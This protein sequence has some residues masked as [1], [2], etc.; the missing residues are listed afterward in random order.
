MSQQ[1]ASQIRRIFM[2]FVFIE[3]SIVTATSFAMPIVSYQVDGSANNWTLDFSVTNNLG[4]S[5][6]IYWF[7]VELPALD[8]TGTPTGWHPYT[9]KDHEE[10][11]SKIIYN[12]VW[13]NDN[14]DTI[15]A[16]LISDGQTFDGFSVLDTADIV[17]PTLVNW[18]AYA[19]FGYYGGDDYFNN[20]Y[21]PGFEG[22]ASD[23]PI[24]V[25]EPSTF[26]LI[27]VGLAMIGFIRKK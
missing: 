22:I 2:L 1:R 27:T 19:K 11:G 16:N 3:T 12:N 26:L 9:L 7:G 17:A 13:I 21:N 6:Y 5:N 8:I 24:A 25:P 23:P 18:F 15:H 4:T 10:G 20:P 14:P